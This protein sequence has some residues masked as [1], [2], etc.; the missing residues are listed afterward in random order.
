MS[1]ELGS[2]F[3]PKRARE[4]DQH[5]FVVISDPDPSGRV[6]MVNLTSCKDRHY[7]GS[8]L[9]ENGDHPWVHEKTYVTYRDAKIVP[10]RQLEAHYQCGN[11][12][13][14]K[15]MAEGLLHR[16]WEG[17]K[18]SKFTPAEVKTLLESQGYIQ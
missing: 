15:N 16:I 11:I 13:L 14:R 17:A 6:A 3:V 8:C 10:S 4:L 5:L 7:D 18:K 1:I 12:E 2:T 9:F